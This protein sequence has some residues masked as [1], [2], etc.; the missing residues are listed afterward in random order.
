MH[1]PLSLLSLGCA[2]V[3]AA[4]CPAQYSWNRV[5]T[6]AQPGYGLWPGMVHFAPTGVSIL[7]GG[8]NGATTS[9][10]TWS[11]D[12]TAWTRLL[13]ATDPGPRHTFGICTDVQRGVVVLFGGS[14]NAYTPQGTT[15]E[16]DPL[17]NTWTQRTP[18][19]GISPGPRYGCSLTYDLVRGVSVLYGGWSGSGF[20]NE[21]W[22]W[23]GLDW[24]Q[25]ATVNRPSGRDRFAFA[26][27]IA[28]AKV[29]LFGGITAAGVSAETWEYDGIDWTLVPTPTSPPPR[30]KNNM[31]FDAARGVMVMQGGQAN[32]VQLLDCW[33]YDGVNWRLVP[34]AP[35]PARG[36]NATAYDVLRATTVVFGGYS[37]GG[38]YTETWEYARPTTARVHR[39]GTGCAGSGGVPSL[40]AQ[41]GGVPTLGTT[42]ALD[43]TNLPA[44]GGIGAVFYGTSNYRFG[45]LWLPLDLAPLGWSGCRAY[46]T[47][48]IGF[49]FVHAAGLGSTS[50]A[51][52]TGAQLAGFTFYG[53]A[54]SLDAA[55]PNGEIALSNAVELILN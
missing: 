30:Q 33:E 7:Y 50:F 35:S 6:A 23:D 38:V 49:A 15:W 22:E 3:V 36:E 4:A 32:A 48:E 2:L 28:R 5:I 24:I 19:S 17:Q 44:A 10:E 11:Y 18:A 14:D 31:E 26:Y 27:D 16:Y 39:F 12:G 29:V 43:V 51:V 52:P 40:Q 46:T 53:Q 21:T 34:S 8:S 13:P 25:V 47:P 20:T 37:T 55:S 9:N 1:H 41:A 45:P 54:V 42:F